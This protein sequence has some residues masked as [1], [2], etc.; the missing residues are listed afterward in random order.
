MVSLRLK[1]L[2]SDLKLSLAQLVIL[3]AVCFLILFTALERPIEYQ[4]QQA[5]GM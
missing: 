2:N 1:L 4:K 5:N 3:I